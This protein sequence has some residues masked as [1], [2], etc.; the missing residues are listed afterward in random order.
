MDYLK[1]QHKNYEVSITSL[2]QHVDE[3][4]HPIKL[5]RK[6]YINK[7]NSEL[8]IENPQPKQ[9]DKQSIQQISVQKLQRKKYLKQL[10]IYLEFFEG[11]KESEQQFG[12][13]LNDLDSK[14]ISEN[15]ITI[16]DKYTEE[17]NDIIQQLTGIQLNSKLFLYLPFW[18]DYKKVL[19]QISQCHTEVA[20]DMGK[21]S[22]QLYQLK[23][24]FLKDVEEIRK[25]RKKLK[26]LTVEIYQHYQ[27][28]LN[29]FIQNEKDL[30]IF[31]QAHSEMLKRK[32]DP[33]QIIKSEMKVKLQMQQ[34]DNIRL[35][36]TDARDRIKEN[37]IE[38]N[39][40]NQKMQQFQ[41][42]Y[43]E[44]RVIFVKQGFQAFLITS[45]NYA[46]QFQ[47]YISTLIVIIDEDY[48]QIYP[49]RQHRSPQSPQKQFLENQQQGQIL[50]LD[51]NEQI[52]EIQRQTTYQLQ[53]WQIVQKYNEELE[54]F[55]RDT[56]Q[57]LNQKSVDK[58]FSLVKQQVEQEK[59]EVSDVF[60]ILY[61]SLISVI[62]IIKDSN[63]QLVDQIERKRQD[64]A[65]CRLDMSIGKELEICA[66][67]ELKKLQSLSTDEKALEQYQND[68]VDKSK[69]K[70]AAQHFLNEMKQNIQDVKS[71]NFGKFYATIG[72]TVSKVQ[73]MSNLKE[74]DLREQQIKLMEDKKALIQLQGFTL[75]KMEDFLNKHSKLVAKM[76]KTLIEDLGRFA[77]SIFTHLRMI[78]DETT[79]NIQIMQQREN[80]DN[81]IEQQVIQNE[82]EDPTY[83]NE[84]IVE[85]LHVSTTSLLLQKL[86]KVLVNDWKESEYFKG[87]I[88]K[89]LHKA[90]NKKR[91]NMLSEITV[92]DLKIAGDPPSLSEIKALRQDVNEFL[93]DLDL[94]F[95]GKIQIV[96]NTNII[97][98]WPKEYQVPVEIK[99]TISTFTS[100]IRL[101]FVP[102]YLGKSW[103]S[104]IGQP[105]INLDIEPTFL[106]K[107]NIA[108]IQQI[109][110]LIREFLIGKVK[111]MTYPNK[112]SIKIPLSKK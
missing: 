17:G 111:L 90:F 7:F 62:Q 31:T 61:T 65:K 19:K 82:K 4:L 37:Q 26:H 25:Q 12:Q 42:N 29:E 110:D 99:I 97:I 85:D 74:D 23:K 100:R 5:K 88:K 41:L 96:L 59:Q 40:F 32:D 50:E 49:S 75:K 52:K 104:M 93:C 112:L 24:G 38:I 106:Q 92:T 98:N 18:K 101:C 54:Y 9:E 21:V 72:Q 16:I 108:K 36:L 84:E 80:L 20:Q 53:Q 2:K 102:T 69:T 94:S 109:A 70:K 66:L 28:I 15:E 68:Q 73:K 27:K 55:F 43:E 47:T 79:E 57:I 89:M 63:K 58:D 103:L 3:Y 107:Y 39:E 71:L 77:I 11:I 44:Q 76:K 64:I 22:F 78:V 30:Q 13:Q 8:Q 51:I 34:Q 91:V 1:Q 83:Q 95:R 105:V 60:N 6:H 48:Y 87:K 35:K 10:D 46:S 14:L 86:L 67:R 33:T 81:Q 45:E 56:I